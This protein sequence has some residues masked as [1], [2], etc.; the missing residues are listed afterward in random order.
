[1]PALIATGYEMVGGAWRTESATEEARAIAAAQ[2]SGFGVGN[3]AYRSGHILKW[4]TEKGESGSKV[5][6]A[7]LGREFRKGWELPK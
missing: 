5:A 7:F 2:T 3:V 6:N 1:M 4:D